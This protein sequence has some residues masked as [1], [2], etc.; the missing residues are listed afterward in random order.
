MVLFIYA[1]S[2]FVVDNGISFFRTKLCSKTL[3]PDMGFL[4]NP[5]WG[6]SKLLQEYVK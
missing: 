4:T 3:K 1:Q 6:V 2:S 5:T